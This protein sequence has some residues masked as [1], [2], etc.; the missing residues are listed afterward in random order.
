MRKRNNI[1][2]FV[3][4]RPILKQCLHCQ[5]KFLS[6]V[7]HKRKYCSQECYWKEYIYHIPWNKGKGKNSPI[8]PI[9]GGRKS[10]SANT[11][12]KCCVPHSLGGKKG[13]IPWNKGIKIWKGKRHPYL[14]KKLSKRHRINLSIAH[15][16]QLPWNTGKKRP[17]MTGKNHPMW[18]GGI[19]DDR[20][21]WKYTQMVKA[22]WKRDKYTCFLCG[23]RENKLDAHHILPWEDFPEWRFNKKNLTTLCKGCH[24]IIKGKEW[25][26]APSFL[27]I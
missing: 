23:K 18:K 1:G 20:R 9:C 6:H 25:F 2:Q 26:Y 8:C 15:Q 11:C 27:D 10:Y 17:E 16:G 4:E 3:G 22:V 24:F 21:S 12:L 5:K 19:T 14:G 7:S 13:N